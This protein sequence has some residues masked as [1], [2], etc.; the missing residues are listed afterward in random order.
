MYVLMAC[1]KKIVIIKRQFCRF[2]KGH[3]P[4]TKAAHANKYVKNRLPEKKTHQLK[5]VT[6]NDFIR[7]T[8]PIFSI[9]YIVYNQMIAINIYRNE[10]K[11]NGSNGKKER[12]NEQRHDTKT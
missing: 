5:M 3:Q 6:I 9:V 12:A 11:R 2:E 7:S 1:Y 8:V 4:N 10:M